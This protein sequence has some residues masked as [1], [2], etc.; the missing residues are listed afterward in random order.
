M[1]VV[2]SVAVAAAVGVVVVVAV[3]ISVAHA[4]LFMF[5]QSQGSARYAALAENGLSKGFEMVTA[6][7]TNS[8]QSFE[9][10]V[11]SHFLQERMLTAT[12][13]SKNNIDNSS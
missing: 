3:V 6:A 10:L 13:S 11:V 5:P 4:Y 9:S 2:A 8:K 12:R 7:I 1:F